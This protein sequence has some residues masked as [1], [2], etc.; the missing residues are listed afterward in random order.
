MEVLSDAAEYLRKQ[1]NGY[2][3]TP[4][5]VEIF[6]TSESQDMYL[7][8]GNFLEESE[9]TVSPPLRESTFVNTNS[10]LYQEI[11]QKYSE[12]RSGLNLTNAKITSIHLS[13]T[14]PENLVDKEVVKYSDSEADA[15]FSVSTTS[16]VPTPIWSHIYDLVVRILS[17]LDVKITRSNLQTIELGFSDSETCELYSVG[18]KLSTKRPHL[19]YR[20]ADTVREYVEEVASNSQEYNN[21]LQKSTYEF[22]YTID[23]PPTLQETVEKLMKGHIAYSLETSWDYRIEAQNILLNNS[24]DNSKD[25]KM[26]YYIR[27]PVVNEEVGAS[28]D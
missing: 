15:R 5:E 20:G 16:I 27:V 23:P 2:S 3:S 28:H 10:E 9:S 11:E 14:A 19:R 8:E 4:S 17:V 26:G 24:T 1:S 13:R 6:Y 18:G 25:N 22:P 12:V 7:I 21:L